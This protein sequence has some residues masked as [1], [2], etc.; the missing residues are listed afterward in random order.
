[1]TN[2]RELIE[3]DESDM[4]DYLEFVSV[5]DFILDVKQLIKDY[6]DKEVIKS[7]IEKLKE[8]L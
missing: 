6:S 8:L 3:K 2:L 5:Q 7:A 1:M 4:C